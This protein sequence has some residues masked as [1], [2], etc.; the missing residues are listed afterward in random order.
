MYL[1]DAVSRQG[2]DEEALELAEIARN[3]AQPGDVWV[4]AGWRQVK[5]GVLARQDERGEAQRLVQEAVE[6]IDSTDFL[7]YR[8][9]VRHGAVETLRLA[10]RA[11][12]AAELLDEA[13]ILFEQKGNVV[14]AERARGERQ[15]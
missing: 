4:Q 12:E 6:L 9:S 15:T 3:A 14:G 8:A 13:A 2:R 1:A 7:P 5:A 10:G 11:E